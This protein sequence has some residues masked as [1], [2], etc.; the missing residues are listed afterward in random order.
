MT[1]QAWD[2]HGW[3]NIAIYNI[4]NFLT[5]V[6]ALTPQEQCMFEHEDLAPSM[7]NEHILQNI[8]KSD[9]NILLDFIQHI[10]L[11]HVTADFICVL[12]RVK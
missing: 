10:M 9:H 4:L 2:K 5:A 1:T 8:N 7:E 11:I 12:E 6:N 3:G